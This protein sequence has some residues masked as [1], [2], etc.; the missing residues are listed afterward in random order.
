MKSVVNVIHCTYLSRHQPLADDPWHPPLQFSWSTAGWA[1]HHARP[2]RA[3]NQS[4]WTPNLL[5][6]IIEWSLSYGSSPVKLVL[7][8]DLDLMIYYFKVK[9]LQLRSFYPVEFA[10]CTVSFIAFQQPLWL[11]VVYFNQL[12]GAAWTRKLGKILFWAVFNLFKINWKKKKFEVPPQ[13]V[14]QRLH[15]DQ[16]WNITTAAEE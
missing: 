5:D 14:D 13:G 15:V 12:L 4:S 11:F 1:F 6:I 2:P 8:L 7:D 10:S 16:I 9:I 3:Y